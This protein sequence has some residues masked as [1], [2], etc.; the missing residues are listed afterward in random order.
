MNYKYL[1]AGIAVMALTTYLIRMLPMVIFRKKISNQWVQSFLYY[2]PY[3]VLAAMTF[4]AIFSST[5]SKESAVAGCIVAVLL[6]YFKRGLLTVALGS[7]TA[8]LIIQLIGY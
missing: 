4:P 6:A 1:L 2:V 8:V 7:A 3:T 5:G